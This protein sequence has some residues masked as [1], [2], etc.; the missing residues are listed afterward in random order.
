MDRN[1]N[2]GS[3][4]DWSWLPAAMPEVARL[5]AAERAKLGNDHVNACWRDGVLAMQPGRFFAA[6]GA[7]TVGVPTA[8][9][10]VEWYE[11]SDPATAPRAVLHLAQPTTSPAVGAGHVA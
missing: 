8:A 9:Q 11:P 10:V 6:E 3:R 4:A 1:R 5:L 7:L 2:R